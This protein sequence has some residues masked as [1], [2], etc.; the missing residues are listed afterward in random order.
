MLP[1]LHLLF[2]DAAFALDDCD[3]KSSLI[4]DLDGDGV[5]AGGLSYFDHGEADIVVTNTSFC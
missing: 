1:G 2:F 5:E 3:P 4:L